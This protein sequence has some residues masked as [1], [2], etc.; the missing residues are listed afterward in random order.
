MGVWI[1]G[2]T[3]LNDMRAILSEQIEKLPSHK[4]R[5]YVAIVEML[6]WFAG[7]QIRN[8]AVSAISY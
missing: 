5:V 3:S 4:S 8:V 1:G 2:A 7:N 6:H